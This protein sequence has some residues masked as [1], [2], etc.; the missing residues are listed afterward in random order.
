M[1]NKTCQ[2]CKKDFTIEPEDFSFYEKMKV[3]APTFCPTCRMIRRFNFRNESL[4][5]RRPD[6]ASGKEVFSGFSPEAPVVTY[7]NGFWYGDAWNPLATGREY[8]FSRSFFE[9]YKEL[10]SAAPLPARSVFN[11]VNSDY[12]NEASEMKNSYLCFNTD[13]VE[14]SA[15]LRKITYIKD[16]FDINDC[17]EDEL[18]YEDVLVDKSYST[19]FSVNCESCVDVWFSK[20]LRGCTNCFGCVNLSKKSYCY[21]NEQCSK[22]EYQEKLAQHALTSF[23]E[24]EKTKNETRDFW[25]Q[26]PVKFNHTSRTTDSTGERIYD[27]KNVKECHSVRGGE[28][29]KY[30]QDIQPKG[31]NSYDYSVWGSGSEN[32]Y[33]CMTCGIGCYNLRFSYCCWENARDLEYCIYCIGSKNCFGC[34]GLYKQEYCIFNKQYSKEEYFELRDKII[35]QMSEV[36]YVDA[37]GR[38]YGYG[39][40]FPYEL[41]PA[42]YNETIAQDF[43]PL[44]ES[45][46]LEKGYQ[47]RTPNN[48]EYKATIAPENLPDDIREV[49]PTITDEILECVSCKR[50]YRITLAELQFYKRV[51]LP[52]PRMCHMCRYADRAYYLNPPMQ[53]PRACMCDLAGHGHEGACP[54][55]FETSYAPERPEI[56]YCESCYQKEVS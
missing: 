52:L 21:F 20:G 17:S 9:Q 7:E 28:N 47:W 51:G 16:C 35:Q 10:L 13:F 12:C 53:W 19:H 3:P 11:L 42:A 1:E 18:C 50:A 15:Y 36:P 25:L 5:F 56:V 49:P 31:S 4:L 27:C 37:K 24:I 33:E 2:N 26:Y 8:D 41:S 34:V 14:N 29:L 55:E 45:E 54:N 30:C 32:M 22:E 43:F 39:E 44:T 46:A 6:G 38:S 23:A 40:F 48:R